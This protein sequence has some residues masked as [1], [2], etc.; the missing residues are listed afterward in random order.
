MLKTNAEVLKY[1]NG[2]FIRKTARGHTAHEVTMPVLLY[3]S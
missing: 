3:R 2:N 1:V